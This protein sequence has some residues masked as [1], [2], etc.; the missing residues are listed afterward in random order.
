MRERDDYRK[1][2]VVGL[3]IMFILIGI[4]ALIG[5]LFNAK[6][7]TINYMPAYMGWVGGFV[8]LIIGLILLFFIIWVLSWVFRAFS[9]SHTYYHRVFWDRWDHDEAVEILRERYAKGEITKE[10]FDQMLADLERDGKR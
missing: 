10:Q 5:A 4:S 9:L 7:Y 3:A 8:G 2:F 1:I 6:N